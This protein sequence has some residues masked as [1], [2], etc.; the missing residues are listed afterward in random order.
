MTNGGVND[1][2]YSDP[3]FDKLVAEATSKTVLSERYSVFAKAEALFLDRCY[4]LPWAMG[5]TAYQITKVVPFTY[6]RGGFG[7]TRFKYKGMIVEK[8]PVTAK[9]Y[10]QLKAAFLQGDGRGEAKLN[11]RDAEVQRAIDPVARGGPRSSR[12]SEPGSPTLPVRATAGGLCV[13]VL[14]RLSNAFE[15]SPMGAYVLK[16]FG[17]SLVDRGHR[18]DLGVPAAAAHA[19]ERVLHPGRL[20][21]AWTR[22]PRTAYLRNLGVLDDPFTPVRS[23]RRPG[24]PRATSGRSITVYPRSPVLDVI[25]EKAP[26]LPLVRPGR[27]GPQH[28]PGPGAGHPH[29]PLQGP[30]RRR[31]WARSTSPS[32]GPSRA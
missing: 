8:D 28:G 17:Q 24:S 14:E 31:G 16:R 22:T 2:Q 13:S 19:Q 23:L 7:I 21:R 27:P 1:G 4:V 25:A 18:G 30:V 5:G 3:E 26:V 29:G 20:R 10:E 6:P 32:S 9:R 12:L 15:G 11:H